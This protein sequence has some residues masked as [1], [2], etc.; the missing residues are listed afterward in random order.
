[1]RKPELLVE[2]FNERR[3]QLSRMSKDRILIRKPIKSY[4]IM[5]NGTPY[6]AMRASQ[7]VDGPEIRDKSRI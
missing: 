4:L 1:M 3:K 7:G 6:G 5:R 2:F